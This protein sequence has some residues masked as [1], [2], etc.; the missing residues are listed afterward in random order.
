M[1]SIE[2]ALAVMPASWQV[3][4]IL[5]HED[6]WV[7][8]LRPKGEC[9]QHVTMHGATLLDALVN[10]IGNIQHEPHKH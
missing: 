2:A 8:C 5:Q 1:N 7:V 4:L 9:G 6:D 10:A 3:G